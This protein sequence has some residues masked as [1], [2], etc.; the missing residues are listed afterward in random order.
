MKEENNAEDTNATENT[1]KATKLEKDGDN[2]SDSDDAP[3]F[4]DTQIKI[5]HFDGTK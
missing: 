5:Q 1:P 3:K 2:S 4:P